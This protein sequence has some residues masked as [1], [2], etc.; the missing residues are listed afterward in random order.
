MKIYLGIQHARDIGVSPPNSV[1]LRQIMDRKSRWPDKSDWFLDSGAFT[2]ITDFCGYPI[3]IQEYKETLTAHN[4]TL[5]STL[6]Y[7]CEEICTYATGADVT[8]HIDWTTEN[9]QRLIDFRDGFVHV[10]QGRSLEDY[11]YAVDQ[12]KSLGLLTPLTGLG[13]LCR[14]NNVPTILYLLKEIRK[15]IPS[16][17]ALHGFGIK[18]TVLRY[19]EAYE[20]LSSIDTYAWNFERFHRIYFPDTAEWRREALKRYRRELESLEKAAHTAQSKLMVE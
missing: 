15:V 18:K 1:S 20:T 4:P 13:T 11:L 12:A 19:K 7:P 2:F 6:D 9:S 14:R 17:I 16:N 10:I 3:S 8:Q 5:W